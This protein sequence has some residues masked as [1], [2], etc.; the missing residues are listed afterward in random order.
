M[1]KNL[2]AYSSFARRGKAAVDEKH[3]KHETSRLG[4]RVFRGQGRLNRSAEIGGGEIPVGEGIQEGFD[5]L[6]TQ[7]AVIDVIGMLPDID[8]Q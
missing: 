2:Y 5:E 8:G 3:A 7:I 1:L 6:G 4:V